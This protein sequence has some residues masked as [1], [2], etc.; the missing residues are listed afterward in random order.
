MYDTWLGQWKPFL[1]LFGKSILRQ[2]KQFCQR[3]FSPFIDLMFFKSAFQVIWLSGLGCKVHQSKT[4]DRKSGWNLM[5]W[6]VI[7]F[8]L[9]QNFWGL[10]VKILP[11][12]NFLKWFY[13][14]AIAPKFYGPFRWIYLLITNWPEKQTTM[15]Q[16]FVSNHWQAN[17][18]LLIVF[19]LGNDFQMKA[20]KIFRVL[21][22]RSGP[23]SRTY[24]QA[25]T[26]KTG[27]VLAEKQGFVVAT[28]RWYMTPS[29]EAVI[30]RLRL[31]LITFL[32]VAKGVEVSVIWCNI[33]VMC[34]TSFW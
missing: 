9:N 13:L 2:R 4:L 26:S 19:V 29:S 24:G 3:I 32:W 5:C 8:S 6:L 12:T 23:F 22:A 27:V 33:C 30:Q 1:W 10:F 21:L 7:R 31:F 16:Y 15:F 25:V 20:N 14:Q 28:Y 17:F 18:V 11:C 34:L